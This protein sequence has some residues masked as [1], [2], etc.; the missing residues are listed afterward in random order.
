MKQENKKAGSFLPLLP[1]KILIASSIRMCS[2]WEERRSTRSCKLPP[3]KKNFNK[4]KGWLSNESAPEEQT[5][6]IYRE[7]SDDVPSIGLQYTRNHSTLHYC[8]DVRM[9]KQSISL[10]FSL[11]APLL[12]RKNKWTTATKRSLLHSRLSKSFAWEQ[13]W[14]Q[15]SCRGL[16]QQCWIHLLQVASPPHTCDHWPESPRANRNRCPFFFLDWKACSIT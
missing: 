7:E 2:P 9:A 4:W 15:C 1:W 3:C 10:D 8:D 11:S 16:N 13:T 12:E 6:L 14:N 5:N